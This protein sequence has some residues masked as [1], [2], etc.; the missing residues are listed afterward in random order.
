VSKWVAVPKPSA[1]LT[2][3]DLTPV[4]E[5][6]GRTSQVFITVNGKRFAE[7]VEPTGFVLWLMEVTS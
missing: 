2:M 7:V 3:V 4:L 5:A 1:Q 6:D